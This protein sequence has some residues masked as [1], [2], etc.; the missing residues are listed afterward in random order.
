MTGIIMMYIIC[1]YPICSMVMEYE[2][3]H[4]TEQ[5]HLNVGRYTRH[6]Y[7]NVELDTVTF[8]LNSC[9]TVDF[10]SLKQL[11]LTR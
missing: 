11:G 1:I 5:N 4:L 2:Y 6:G 7:M 10:G 8:N 3:Q 9:R